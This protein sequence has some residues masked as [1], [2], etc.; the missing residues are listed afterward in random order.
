MTTRTDC[1]QGVLDEYRSTSSS[2]EVQ[3]KSA[4]Y[5]RSL[6]EADSAADVPAEYAAY[7]TPERL[8]VDDQAIIPIYRAVTP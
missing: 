6:T 3:Y 2:N 8:R 5:D 4:A 1:R 7:A